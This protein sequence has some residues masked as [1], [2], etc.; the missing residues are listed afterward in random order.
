M[1]RRKSKPRRAGGVI[2]ETS[3]TAETE[4]NKQNVVEGRE[5][6]K[7]DSSG[8]DKPYFVEVDWS[9]WLSSEHLDISEV[10][11]RD[12]DLREGF[13]GFELSEDFHQDPQYLLRFRVCNVSNVLG[14]IK[15]G[16]WPV[17]PYT[18]IHLEVVRRVTVEKMETYTVLLSGIF[19]GPD[20]GVTGLLH[21]VS[22]KFVTL[23][24]VLGVRLSEEISSL[25]VRVE[26]LK[27]A[28][29][30]CESLLDTSR[31]LWKKS[32]VNVMSW[33]RPEIMTSEVRYG[34]GSCMKMEVDPQT[35][36]TDDTCNTR[37]HAR[38]DP[39][40]FYEAIKPSKAEPMLEDDIPELLPKLRPYQLRAAFWMVEREKAV[41]E[42]QGERERNQFH[43]PLCIPVD[44]LDTSSQMF[45]NPFR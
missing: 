23:R 33:L 41:E 12:L 40:G 27:S 20:E 35:E 11:L 30:A 38:F 37:K 21:L 36:M 3:A 45:F 10:V 42:S 26:V 2:L 28:F 32:M 44:F 24:P 5:E 7:G 8:I 29:D 25:R 43:S 19:D 22:L 1:G 31:Q 9:G 39:A 17:L 16:H 18:D 34:F 14:R 6:E 13:S 15:L 4:L